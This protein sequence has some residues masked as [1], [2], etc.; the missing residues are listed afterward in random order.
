L[1]DN[2]KEIGPLELQVDSILSSLIAGF[3]DVG[4]EFKLVLKNKDEVPVSESRIFMFKLNLIRKIISLFPSCIKENILCI[5][6]LALDLFD[7]LI[8]SYQY[9]AK[10]NDV[11][12]F[13][14]TIMNAIAPTFTL[15][16]SEYVFLNSVLLL[17]FKE[18]SHEL[19]I[20]HLLLKLSA[21]SNLLHKQ[22]QDKMPERK[23]VIQKIFIMLQS[24]SS[25]DDMMLSSMK[26]PLSLFNQ[27]KYLQTLYQQEKNEAIEPVTLYKHTY[28]HLNEYSKNILDSDLEL[29]LLR[30]CLQA[31]PVS[32][33]QDH[34]YR[35][36]RKALDSHSNWRQRPEEGRK[37]NRSSPRPSPSFDGADESGISG[38]NSEDRSGVIDVKL[39]GLTENVD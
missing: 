3:L 13:Q 21:I 35:T 17:D 7:L 24:N 29:Q 39:R 31:A 33:P 23:E 18:V 19:Q 2:Y 10:E 4:K 5:V 37:S 15:F 27:E 1:L 30:N 25:R 11:T 12:Q 14:N 36:I 38:D 26:V 16:C 32:I 9:S 28:I 8:L 6:T 20:P 34:L 22:D